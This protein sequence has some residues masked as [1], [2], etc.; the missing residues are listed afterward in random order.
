MAKH[1]VN[2]FTVLVLAFVTY[3]AA[4][5]GSTVQRVAQTSFHEIYAAVWFLIA[6]VAFAGAAV[7]VAL[8]RNTSAVEARTQTKAAEVSND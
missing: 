7:V 3:M 5:M 6:T 1:V 8:D 4:D 2:A